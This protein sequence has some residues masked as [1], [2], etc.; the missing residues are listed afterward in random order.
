M[1]RAATASRRRRGLALGR[2]LPQFSAVHSPPPPR[3][4]REPAVN[5][6]S[7]VLWSILVL[8]AIHGVRVFLLSQE[9]DVDVLLLFAFIPARY[10]TEYAGILPGGEGADVWTFLS[11]SLLHGDWTHLA[12]NGFWLA[13]FGSAV[14]WR[15]GTVRFLLF[16]A[17]TAAAGAATHLAMHQGELVPMIGASAAIS[18]QMAAAI[19]FAFHN[20]GPLSGM[21]RQGRSAFL[22]PAESLG[23]VLRDPQVLIFLGVWFVLNLAFGIGSSVIPGTEETSIAW[24]AHIGGFLAGLLG[25]RVFDPVPPAGR[26]PPGRL[27]PHDSTGGSVGDPWR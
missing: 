5:L 19:R 2:L 17:L 26:L 21:R 20:G 13:A 25:F 7:V 3:S 11:Y 14:A 8:A 4:Y 16:S 9:Q 18:G 10:G 22:A 15:F 23:R 6:P 27:T 12:V 1:P 24:E